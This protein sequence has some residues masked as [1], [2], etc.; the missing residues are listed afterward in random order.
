MDTNGTYTSILYNLLLLYAAPPSES[1]G[2]S[3]VLSASI[4]LTCTPSIVS[5]D[6]NS[7]CA[8]SLTPAG[9]ESADFRESDESGSRSVPLAAAGT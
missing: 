1:V 3:F 4:Q 7:L 5:L 2:D 8:I 6:S 9:P